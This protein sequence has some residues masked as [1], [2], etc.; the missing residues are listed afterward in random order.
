MNMKNIIHMNYFKFS[1]TTDFEIKLKS[2]NP[3]PKD[4]FN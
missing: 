1:S 3:K 2:P 4:K